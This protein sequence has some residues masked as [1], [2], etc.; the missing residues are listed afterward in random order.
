MFDNIS[1][2]GTS[3]EVLRRRYLLSYISPPYYQESYV[4]KQC[5]IEEM[6][7]AHHLRR[8]RDRKRQERVTKHLAELGMPT[9]GLAK[10]VTKRVL[11]LPESTVLKDNLLRRIIYECKAEEAKKKQERGAREINNLAIPG[12]LPLNGTEWGGSITEIPLPTAYRLE[13]PTRIAIFNKN[14]PFYAE[15]TG[16]RQV[17]LHFVPKNMRFPDDR[18]MDKA[19]VGARKLVAA[20]FGGMR[21]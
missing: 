2:C 9:S 11:A 18:L 15:G 5:R 3:E 1:S 21:S 7:Y 10:H 20:V 17:E 12:A 4:N 8:T 19:A 14:D 6:Q 13:T 16:I